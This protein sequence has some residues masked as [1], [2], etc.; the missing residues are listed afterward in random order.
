MRLVISDTGP[1]NYLV[2][3]GHTD[4]LPALFERIFIPFAV[5]EELKDSVA[6]LEVRRWIVDPP[7]WLEVHTVPAHSFHDDSLLSL[8]KGEREAISLAAALQTD[9]L[10]LIDEREGVKAALR[11]G[12]NVTGTIGVLD[13]AAKRGFLDLADAFDRLRQTNFHRPEKL[14]ERMLAEWKQRGRP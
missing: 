10:L 3:I 11:K 1:I 2:L 6:P 13:L 8:D 9:T 5:Q 7:A 12:L 14:M 4:L